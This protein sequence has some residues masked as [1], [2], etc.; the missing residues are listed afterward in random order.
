MRDYQAD[1]PILFSTD[2]VKAIL[3]GRKT[4]TR[5]V[6]KPQPRYHSKGD[7]WLI[8]TEYWYDKYKPGFETLKKYCPYPPGTVL[9][10]REAWA[11]VSDWIEVDPE[12]GIPDGYIYKADWQ[13][14]ECPRWRPSIHMPKSAA[15]IWLEVT[16]VKVERVQDI[17]C[18]DM[19]A[20]GCI[21]KTV[22]GGQW[23]QWQHDYW[24][25]LWNSLNAKQG[26]SWEVNPWVWAISFRRKQDKICT[27]P[28]MFLCEPDKCEVKACNK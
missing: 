19:L 17:L 15:R 18:N 12:V 24:R 26:Y 8:N 9:Y 21:P 7:Y 3:E 10:V 25:P 2:M 14:A 23:Q 16:G 5:R 22:K 4:M 13:G 6:I 20:E 27:R 28:D 1:K 11:K